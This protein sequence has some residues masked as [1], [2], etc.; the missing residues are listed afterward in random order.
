M[1]FRAL[2]QTKKSLTKWCIH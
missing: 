1:E 2:T